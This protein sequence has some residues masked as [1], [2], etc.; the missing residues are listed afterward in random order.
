MGGFAGFAAFAPLPFEKAASAPPTTSFNT[1]S[2][3][4]TTF[5]PKAKQAAMGISG[6]FPVIGSTP[7]SASVEKKKDENA[8]PCQGKPKEF[9]IYE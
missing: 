7:S 3:G 9:F 5:I 8:D 2:V 1:S 4:G 6:N